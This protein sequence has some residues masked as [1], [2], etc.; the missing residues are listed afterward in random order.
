V[1]GQLPFGSPV[2]RRCGVVGLQSETFAGE[3]AFVAPGDVIDRPSSPGEAATQQLERY[4][5]STFFGMVAWLALGWAAAKSVGTKQ[6]F[7][8]IFKWI[9]RRRGY[10]RLPTEREKIY[11]VGY[12]GRE[13][14]CIDTGY[15]F[16]V[17]WWVN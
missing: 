13:W 6:K 16:V 2:A 12:A 1:D 15:V 10:P 9:P 5:N 17:R 7:W 14:F 3:S 4:G 8:G 11:A